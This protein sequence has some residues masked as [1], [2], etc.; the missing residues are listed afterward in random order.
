M[1]IIKKALNDVG[2]KV[3]I[4]RRIFNWLRDHPNKT[5]REIATALNERVEWIQTELRDMTTRSMIK[6]K[7]VL[8]RPYR[9]SGRKS[10]LEYAVAISEYELLPLPRSIANVKI[11]PAPVTVVKFDKP[12]PAPVPTVG[13][14]DV[15]ALPIGEARRIYARLQE[16]FG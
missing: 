4:K 7:P 15:D 11:D 6:S 13:Q 8:H 14:I 1:N 9:G 3:P 12:E 16:I 2:I 10:L 5:S